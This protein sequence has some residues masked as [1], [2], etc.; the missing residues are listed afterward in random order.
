LQ[1]RQG[2]RTGA[3]AV[4]FI[5]DTISQ[6]SAENPFA[7]AL[8]SPAGSI[9]YE[10]VLDTIVKISNLFDDRRL[11]RMGRAY[12]NIREPELRLVT[13]IA[14]LTYG[15]IPCIAGPET[16]K[17]DYDFDFTIGARVGLR[18]DVPVDVMIDETVLGGRL[19]DGRRR[20]FADRSGDDIAFIT[21][22]TGTTGYPK[23]IALSAKAL[24]ASLAA[25]MTHRFAK[26][27]RLMMMIGGI[28]RYAANI[29]IG[30]LF[31]GAAN[32]SA[33]VDPVHA[34]KMMALFEVTRLL[35]TPMVLAE[36]MDE[37]ERNRLR[38]P[39]VKRINVT[40]SL[41]NIDLVRRIEANFDA[42]I[43][44]GYGTSEA[45]RLAS[46][47]ISSATFRHG[48][49]GE[50]D[51]NVTVVSAGT[52]AEPAPVVITNNISQQTQYIVGGKILSDDRPT[53]TLPDLGYLE[54]T[55]LFLTGR[56]DEVYNF[57]GNKLAFDAI[58]QAIRRLAQVKDIGIVNAAP[59]GLDDDLVVAV[60]ADPSINLDDV[61][62]RALEGLGWAKAAPHFRFVQLPAVPRN[63]T[64]KV[65][66]RE[67]LRLYAE[68]AKPA[69]V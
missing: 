40:G 59:I 4:Q 8:I 53:L 50:V 23:L 34:L 14:A 17:R 32:V 3:G 11:P 54:G 21:E 52:R 36:M 67:V 26:D 68:R 13:M 9:G 1:S 28:S 60:T 48:Y 41:M 63:A 38:A 57:G 65:D 45:S 2:A 69:T 35:T 64:G 43:R 29:G 24:R 49:V 55:S 27:D 20:T 56:A 58:D 61:K 15:L 46:G 33:P 5:L 51:P 7:P 16:L 19:A 37:M 62:R 66:R 47:V 25:S 30:L 18:P 10:D 22:T 42:E 31:A 39:S 6:R 12:V 44:V